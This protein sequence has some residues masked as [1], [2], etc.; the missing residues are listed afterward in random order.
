MIWY[1]P[2]LGLEVKRDWERYATHPLGIGT[3]QMEMLSY[4]I[5]N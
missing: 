4:T 1:E 2:K 3:H 5:K